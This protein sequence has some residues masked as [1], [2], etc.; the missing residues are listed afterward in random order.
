MQAHSCSSLH[1]PLKLSHM[2]GGLHCL[3]VMGICSAPVPF[4][5]KLT[6]VMMETESCSSLLKIS[7]SGTGQLFGST[8]LTQQLDI[9]IK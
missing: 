4:Q 1:F 9:K 2:K 8:S 3:L 7:A 6:S 5:I